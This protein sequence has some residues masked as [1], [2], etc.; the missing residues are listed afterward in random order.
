MSYSEFTLKKVK[1]D[2]QIALIEVPSF[3]VYAPPIQP[4]PA[5]AEF[6]EK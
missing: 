2:F 1:Q 6:I 3:I 4:S 5:L